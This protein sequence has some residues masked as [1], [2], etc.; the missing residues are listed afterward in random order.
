M[1]T[2]LADALSDLNEATLRV[3]GG[4]EQVTPGQ[5]EAVITSVL[6]RSI[7]Q[8]LCLLAADHEW[9]PSPQQ[10]RDAAVELLEIIGD[11]TNAV[12]ALDRDQAVQILDVLFFGKPH[13]E[14]HFVRYVGTSGHVNYPHHPGALYDCPA[15][16][17]RCH[18]GPDVA[19]GNDTECIWSGHEEA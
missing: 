1:T 12:A 18:C 7:V 8:E 16:E 17:A 10:A 3:T 6:E 4:R 14:R 11:A 2:S 9:V 15:C 13:E 19:A 5:A